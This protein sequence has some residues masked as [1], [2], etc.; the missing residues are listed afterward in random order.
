M[1]ATVGCI[2]QD[3]GGSA[4]QMYCETGLAGQR[5]VM[6]ANNNENISRELALQENQCKEA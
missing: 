4:N 2:R 3:A 1:F 5:R 6:D